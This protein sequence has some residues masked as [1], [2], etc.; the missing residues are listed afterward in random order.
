MFRPRRPPSSASARSR[1]PLRFCVPSGD[2]PKR[3]S[4]SACV[5][6]TTIKNGRLVGRPPAPR[7]LRMA[8]PPLKS[9]LLRANTPRA[10]RVVKELMAAL[11]RFP[12][13]V[14][15]IS[16]LNV[17]PSSRSRERARARHFNSWMELIHYAEPSESRDA[18][19][20]F[21]PW[22]PALNAPIHLAAATRGISG[23]LYHS[24]LLR[25][26]PS[27]TCPRCGWTIHSCGFQVCHCTG[28]VLCNC[29]TKSGKQPPRLHTFLRREMTEALPTATIS[30]PFEL[31]RRCVFLSNRLLNNDGATLRRVVFYLT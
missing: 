1:P 28:R 5:T 3:K 19:G 20:G 16:F 25:I 10:S 11:M 31:L 30:A 24:L 14:Y 23:V 27:V 4:A 21:R 6:T 7:S 9:L 29:V 8:T 22:P 13:A 17:A 12:A 15:Q 18:S 26:L 2:S